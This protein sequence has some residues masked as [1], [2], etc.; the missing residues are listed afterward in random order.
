M[1]GFVTVLL[2]IIVFG[3]LIFIHELGHFIA[4]KSV[5]VRVNE[6]AL[7][8]G[9]VL[10]KI[11]KGETQYAIRLLPIGGFVSMEG[12]DPSAEDVEQI[13]EAQDNCAFYK[14]KVWQRIIIV[15]AGAVMNILLGFLIMI[16]ITASDELLSTRVVANFD[17]GAVS[18][19]V[20]RENDEI[21]E[22]NSSKINIA[23]D[24]IFTMLRDDDGYVDMTV[25]RDGQK[26]ELKDVPFTV[27]TYED[28]TK[29][30]NIDFK[31][32]GTQK[33]FFGVIR[34]S[35]YMTMSVVRSVW[36][37][38]IDLVTGKYSMSQLSGPVGTATAIGQASSLGLRSLLMMVVMITVNL[39]VFNLLPL[40]ALD[41]GRLLFL[42]IEAVRRKPIKPQYEGYVHMVGFLLLMGL[43]L[44]VTFNDILK[45]F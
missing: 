42:L 31:V 38:L 18:N 15:V 12:E 34:E 14:K 10:F 30:M 35:W 37:S 11:K 3:I 28:G 6:F 24:I 8:M 21:L 26:V 32:Y 22:V 5:G 45:L 20:L 9:P 2:A 27:V 25:M 33:T 36:T 16:G 13:D 39:G 23:N 4:A 44:V 43:V 19:S 7:G 1:N 17:E 40:P 29:A 41:G